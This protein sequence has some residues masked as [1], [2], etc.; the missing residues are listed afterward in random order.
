MSIDGNKIYRLS[1][2][3]SLPSGVFTRLILDFDVSTFI[4]TLYAS[5]AI[6]DIQQTTSMTLFVP[7]NEAFKRVGLVSRYLVHPTGHNDLRTI[8]HYHAVTSTLYYQDL[9]HD[10]LEVTTLANASMII[11]GKKDD[12]VMIGDGVVE[13][14]DGLVANGVVHK[15]DHLQIPSIVNI[16]Q[17]DL[18]RGIQATTILNI[19]K[20]ANVTVDEGSV[21]LAPTDQAFEKQ[22]D[23]EALYNDTKKLEKLAKLH[24]LPKSH[25]GTWFPLFGEQEYETLMGDR[26]IMRDVGFG[27]TVVRVKGETYATHARVLEKGLLS[28][29]GGVLE[30]DTV[31]FPVERGVF[32]LPWIWSFTLLSVLTLVGLSVITVAGYIGVK[33]WKRRH[34]VEI[35]E[36]EHTS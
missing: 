15:I 30:I 21:V 1:D 5:G 27:I 29:G 19:L 11:D 22:V 6:Q 3:L 13:E 2:P 32:G 31:L 33:K 20:R 10:I 9:I 26:V 7:T 8:L 18:L 17:L 35:S 23:L 25:R 36:E 12:R 34:Y 4:A 16:T 24:V 28:H 14:A